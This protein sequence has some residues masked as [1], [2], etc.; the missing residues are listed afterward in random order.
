M[1]YMLV[2]SVLSGAANT[3]LTHG[4]SIDLDIFGARIVPN[5]ATAEALGV[6]AAG[7]QALF[8]LVVDVRVVFRPIKSS[9]Q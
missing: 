8:D 9:N 3:I 1:K 4:V 6:K 7:P 5:P 2:C